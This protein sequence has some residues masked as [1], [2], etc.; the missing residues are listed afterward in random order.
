MNVKDVFNGF[1]LFD[2]WYIL[3]DV[4]FVH[5]I[6]SASRLVNDIVFCKKMSEWEAVEL[7]KLCYEDSEAVNEVFR[8][9][10]ECGFS[11]DR[12]SFADSMN[13]IIKTYDKKME[14]RDHFRNH[15]TA[16]TTERNLA[17]KC[18]FINGMKYQEL[19]DKYKLTPATVVHIV[20]QY[21]D[22]RAINRERAVQRQDEIYSRRKKVYVLLEENMPLKEIAKKT[23][24]TYNYVRC[25]NEE[26]KARKLRQQIRSM[27]S[28]TNED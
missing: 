12:N 26:Y 20:N 8:R 19:S 6:Y 21:E 3:T 11:F 23:G 24:F 27:K 22:C 2:K 14:S 1:T 5:D 28:N 17:L 10:N 7:L 18:D 15:Q 4:P 16:K 9:K 25:R 13:M